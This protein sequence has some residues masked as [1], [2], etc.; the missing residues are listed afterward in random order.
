MMEL[1][2]NLRTES[3]ARLEPTPP[4]HVQIDQPVSA[5]I[6]M[7]RKAKIGCVLVCQHAKL[8]GI[9]TERDMMYRILG[10]G[11]PLSLPMRECMTPD[12][13]TLHRKDTIRTAIKKMKQGG[14]RHLPVI[15][16]ENTPTGV[17]SVRKII[18]YLVEH[19]PGTVY[20]LHPE[21]RRGL[22]EREGA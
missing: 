3:I 14:Y 22:S 7:M 16:E 15:D 18:R 2:R 1:I 12:P 11:K 8:V 6:E 13:V 19:F 9:F 10:T 21:P 5:A 4:R 17:L 20:N